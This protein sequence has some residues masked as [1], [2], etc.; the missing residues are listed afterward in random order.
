MCL[1]RDEARSSCS[2]A[3]ARYV[4]CK[5]LQRTSWIQSIFADCKH[6][7]GGR[8][9]TFHDSCHG[10]CCLY[11]QDTILSVR[12]MTLVIE[13]MSLLAGHGSGFATRISN[14]HVLCRYPAHPGCRLARKD[15]EQH[16]QADEQ[17]AAKRTFTN[18][19]KLQFFLRPCYQHRNVLW[20][21]HMFNWCRL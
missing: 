9:T 14:C 3:E 11:R 8:S 5:R 20:H 17:F 1:A 7:W 10:T 15:T 2:D 18:P 19:G 12:Q 6:K 16:C 13:R 21:L 4:S